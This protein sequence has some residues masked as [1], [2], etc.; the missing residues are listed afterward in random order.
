MSG[1]GEIKSSNSNLKMGDQDDKTIFII[2]GPR[3]EGKDSDQGS[4]LEN[5]IDSR[6][7]K[8]NWIVLGQLSINNEKRAFKPYSSRI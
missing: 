7:E 6:T 3:E 5:W 2:E 8:D 1:G 4:L